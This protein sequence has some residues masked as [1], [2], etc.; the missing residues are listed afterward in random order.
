MP[1]LPGGF[2]PAQERA[3]TD[4]GYVPGDPVVAAALAGFPYAIPVVSLED[5]GAIRNVSEVLSNT[6]VVF[7]NAHR[8]RLNETFDAMRAGGYAS[9]SE[10]FRWYYHLIFC[11]AIDELVRRERIAMPEER[12]ECWATMIR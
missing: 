9:F 7:F 5:I 2:L 4:S 12:F 3:A 10:F 6:L 8:D 11:E 1:Q